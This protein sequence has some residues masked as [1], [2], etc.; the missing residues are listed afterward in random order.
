MA[1]RGKGHVA[2]PNEQ[3]ARASDEQEERPRQEVAAFSR[4]E[5][6]HLMRVAIGVRPSEAAPLL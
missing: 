1:W 2:Q 5:Q 3:E 6:E 4:L